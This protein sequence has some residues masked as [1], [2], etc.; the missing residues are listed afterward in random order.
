LALHGGRAGVRDA[1]LLESALSRPQNRWVY[2]ERTGIVELAA[3]YTAGVIGNHPFI[4][5]NKRTGFVVG[6]LFLELNGYEF[7]AS[8]EDAV[9][10]VLALAAGVMNE[11][12]YAAFLAVNSRLSNN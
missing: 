6:V 2:G 4:D 7:F 11:E 5:G 3:A 9:E 1:G 12:G 8:E 10:A